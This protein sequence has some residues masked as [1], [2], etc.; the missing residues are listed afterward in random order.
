MSSTQ[1]P[2]DE[3]LDRRPQRQLAQVLRGD[4]SRAL[5][6]APT[7]RCSTRPRCLLAATQSRRPSTAV[8][9]RSGVS[10]V[11][12][13]GV[14]VFSNSG[15]GADAV[16]FSLP[17]SFPTHGSNA[18]LQHCDTEDYVYPPKSPCP[19]V[20]VIPFTLHPL[21]TL[22]LTHLLLLLNFHLVI[23]VPPNAR[24]PHHA[25]LAITSFLFSLLI[26]PCTDHS[27]SRATLHRRLR[28][29]GPPAAF[30]TNHA[31]HVPHIY[32]PL[33]SS[34]SVPLHVRLIPPHCSDMFHCPPRP[35]LLHLYPPHPFLRVY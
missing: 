3:W 14:C 4:F 34:H 5:L 25:T 26:R 19:Y 12:R 21:S 33:A 13:S 1:K 27:Y 15:A 28:T 16:N 11:L 24:F 31:I 22:V 32:P 7:R 17:P 29:S 8:V 35:S 9:F 10:A 2:V 6:T 18:A 20:R 23:A 30:L